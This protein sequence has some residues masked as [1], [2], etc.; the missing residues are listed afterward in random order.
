MKSHSR[1]AL[2]LIALIVVTGCASTNVTQQT[3]M[4]NPG[5]ARPNQIWVYN[6]VANS[7]DMPANSSIGGEVGAPSTPPTPEQIQEGRQLGALIAQQLVADINAM[8]LSAVQAGPGSVA[9][10]WRWRDSR[11][12]RIDPE[13][14]RGAALRDRIRRR[15]FGDGYGGGGLC[16]H[17]ARLAQTGIG[18]AYLLGK[19]NP[20]DGGASRGGD[21]DRQSDRSDRRRRRETVQRG[22]RQGWTRGK[23]QGDRRRNRRTAEDQVP[24]SG[25]DPVSRAS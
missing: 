24:G 11:L 15:N 8:G 3:P 13:W 25:L 14:Q 2:C 12:S 19:Q 22:Q 20:R 6:F 21:C 7:A 18:N 17:A 16:G 1:Y 23:S 5:L 4:S 9:A 10:G